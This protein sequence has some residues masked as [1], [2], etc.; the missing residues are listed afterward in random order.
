M[1]VY[2]IEEQVYHNRF[3]VRYLAWI[4]GV[5]FG[6]VKLECPLTLLIPGL[7]INQLHIS[8]L[9]DNVHELAGKRYDVCFMGSVN[10]VWQRIKKANHSGVC[11][12]GICD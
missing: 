5:D 11:G 2:T 10:S 3:S 4:D 6:T 1:K 9:S 8:K 7:N 12:I